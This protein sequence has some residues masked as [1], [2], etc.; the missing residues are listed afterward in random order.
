MART[1]ILLNDDLDLPN[2]GWEEG[3][4]DEQHVGLLLLLQKGELKQF[5][6][7]GFGLEGRLKGVYEK[8][9]FKRELLVEL[10]NDGYSSAE[11]EVGETPGDFTIEI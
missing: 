11:V 6:W 3:P 2:E 5:P 10:E 9:R 1:D 8:V 7:A 4:S